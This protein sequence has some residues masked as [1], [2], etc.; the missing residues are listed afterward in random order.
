MI[1]ENATGAVEDL[2]L[3]DPIDQLDTDRISRYH[4]IEFFNQPYN[5]SLLGK[6]WCQVITDNDPDQPLMRSNVFTLL[7]PGDYRG[8]TCSSI[9]ELKFQVVQNVMCAD[10]T[11]TI[12][13]TMISN[14]IMTS[15]TAG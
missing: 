11:Q 4:D 13:G 15:A 2:G 8:L 6:Y 3:G 10:L 5:P 12:S 7:A 1:R 14:T 9:P